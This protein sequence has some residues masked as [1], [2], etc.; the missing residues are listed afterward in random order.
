MGYS[1]IEQARFNMVEQQIRPAEVLDP[2]VLSVIEDTPR[3]EYVPVKYRQLAFSDTN[4]PLGHGQLM[5]SPIMEGRCARQSIVR[6]ADSS[7]VR[8]STCVTSIFTFTP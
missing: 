1:N 3:E 4:I 5:M 8:R 2:R 6:E 7:F